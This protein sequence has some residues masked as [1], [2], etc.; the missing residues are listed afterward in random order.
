VQAWRG[1]ALLGSGQAGVRK[2]KRLS[3]VRFSWKMM[4]TF[5]ICG[6]NWAKAAVE[7]RKGSRETRRFT[8]DDSWNSG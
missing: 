4:T 1:G 8:R 7:S 3:G 6:G 2:W 5:L